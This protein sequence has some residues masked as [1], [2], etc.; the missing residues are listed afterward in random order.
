MTTFI[1]TT[2]TFTTNTQTLN[3]TK[4]QHKL[5]QNN[6]NLQQTKTHTHSQTHTDTHTY[7]H[8]QSLYYRGYAVT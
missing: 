1:H 5:T 3:N 4:K 8:T 7:S 6:T 2:D